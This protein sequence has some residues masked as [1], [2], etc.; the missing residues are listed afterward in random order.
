MKKKKKKKKTGQPGNKTNVRVQGGWDGY[1]GPQEKRL[2]AG[3]G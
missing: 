1:W 2:G 3:D